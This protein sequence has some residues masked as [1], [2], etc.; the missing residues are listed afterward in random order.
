MIFFLLQTVLA[1][2][3]TNLTT[4]VLFNKISESEQVDIV[5]TEQLNIR[6]YPQAKYVIDANLESKQKGSICYVKQ[7]SIQFGDYQVYSQKIF[8]LPNLETNDPELLLNIPVL[9]NMVHIKKAFAIVT[10]NNQI[11]LY[12]VNN[13]SSNII[14]H[15]IQLETNYSYHH[16]RQ[17][18]K[19]IEP[20]QIIYADQTQYIYLIYANQILGGK[21]NYDNL[22][23]FALRNITNERFDYETYYLGQI[24][25][26]GWHIFIPVGVD[27]LDIYQYQENGDW[28]FIGNMNSKTFYNNSRKIKIVDLVFG[29]TENEK[30]MYILDEQRGIIRFIVSSNSSSFYAQLDPQLGIITIS[31][32]KTL[33][34]HN[35]SYIL[36][37]QEIGVIN[38]LVEVG[39]HQNGWFKVKVHY[40]TGKYS[41]IDIL[42]EFTILRGKDEHRII[43]TGIYEKFEPNFVFTQKDNLN[44]ERQNSFYEEYVFIPSLITM[45]FYDVDKGAL[46]SSNNFNY[47]ITNSFLV[48]ITSQSIVYMP[49]IVENP[50][51]RCNPRSNRTVGRTFDYKLT[52][53]ATHCPQKEKLTGIPPQLILCQYVD[54]FNIKI[55]NGDGIIYDTESLASIV[56]G[57]IVLLIILS[58]S[59][60][61]LYTRYKLKQNGLRNDIQGF[62]ES[63]NR[64]GYD[65]DQ[66]Y[67]QQ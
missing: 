32:G 37:L 46:N 41:E 5:V 20:P 67:T 19:I 38:T 60:A 15:N 63:G 22:S 4:H 21:V 16:L 27:G 25:V 24:K 33:A 64:E 52:I 48:G 9:L 47:N 54:E 8:D 35:N 65:M 56:M 12:R 3:L 39:L 10:S 43:R 23:S 14:G 26:F 53:N 17:E 28:S 30:Y 29:G 51:I 36:V 42:P 7:G 34:E 31:N 2:Q 50:Y 11:L 13:N 6:D 45:D 40:L 49:Y 62:G 58:I 57:F 66:Q 18:A 55:T 61:Y 44:Q 1:K 59:L